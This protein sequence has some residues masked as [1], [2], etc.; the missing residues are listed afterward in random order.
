MI[1]LHSDFSSRYTDSNNAVF[2][3]YGNFTAI[4]ITG[5]EN[6]TGSN[7]IFISYHKTEEGN[8]F[9]NKPTDEE[10]YIVQIGEKWE[11]GH[12]VNQIFKPLS[13]RFNS[14]LKDLLLIKYQE[15]E[16]KAIV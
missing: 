7:L 10:I 14:W 6:K 4:P 11:I 3:V 13:S 1:H 8:G 16:S 12:F 2:A 9:I 5:E 15:E